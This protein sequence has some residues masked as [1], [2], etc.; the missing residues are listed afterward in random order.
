M[1]WFGWVPIVLDAV[2]AVAAIIKW[3]HARTARAIGDVLIETI[4]KAPMPRPQRKDLKLN[5]RARSHAAGVGEKLH[6]RV[7]AKGYVGRSQ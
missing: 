7:T 2:L 4:E 1:S 3:K 6:A 5:A